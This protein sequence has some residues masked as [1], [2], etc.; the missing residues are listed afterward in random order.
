[1]ATASS[2]STVTISRRAV[3]S[4]GVGLGCTVLGRHY[5]GDRVTAYTQV[6]GAKSVPSNFLQFDNTS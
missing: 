3:Y 6:D 2:A 4:N 5:Y 1:M